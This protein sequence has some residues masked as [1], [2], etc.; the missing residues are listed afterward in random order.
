MAT[1]PLSRADLDFLLHDW[2]QVEDL[3]ALPRYADHSRETFESV[4][5]VSEDLATHTFR[6]HN[7]ASDL[8]EPT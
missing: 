6:P 1:T 3:T 4:L 2:L 5:R 8:Q 7:R